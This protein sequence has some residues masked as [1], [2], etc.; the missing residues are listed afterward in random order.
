MSAENSDTVGINSPQEK[1]P[2]GTLWCI[3]SSYFLSLKVYILFTQ[4]GDQRG[5]LCP[6][7]FICVE[8]R[9]LISCFVVK[10]D[11]HH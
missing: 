4:T 9:H 7:T 11:Q 10:G 2:T 6:P 8:I 5:F 1:R 3:A